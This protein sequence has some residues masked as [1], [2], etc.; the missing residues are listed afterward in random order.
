LIAIARLQGGIRRPQGWSLSSSEPQVSRCF[1]LS[2]GGDLFAFVAVN[3]SHFE[4]RIWAF[5]I[6]SAAS[7]A[8]ANAATI[9][10]R[11]SFAAFF[12]DGF[13]HFC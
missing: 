10:H 8:F 13:R 1:R 2:Y 11:S 6:V 5:E 12:A 7:W 4:S 3:F 9:E